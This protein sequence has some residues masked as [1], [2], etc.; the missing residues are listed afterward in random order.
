MFE[1][2]I[3]V[4][5]FSAYGVTVD[6]HTKPDIIA[7]GRNIVSVL[8]ASSWW[9]NDNPDR[10][11]DGGY[12]RIS[13]TSMAAPVVSGTVALLLQAEPDLT[14]DQVKYRLMNTGST[15]VADDNE[16]YPYL[17]AYAAVTTVTTESVNLGLEVSQLL[18]PDDQSEPVVWGSVAWNSVAWNS[19]GL[20]LSR[21]ELCGL[22]LGRLEQC[23][24]ELGRLEQR[25]LE[26]VG[27]GRNYHVQLL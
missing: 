7:P 20:E 10:F 4:T 22:E 17:D 18:W 23:G 11:V 3:L 8:A 12:F 6:G 14:P 16:G 26:R 13:G 25:G 24:L 2:M 21:L 1:W 5:S 15:I 27:K 19:C 9:R